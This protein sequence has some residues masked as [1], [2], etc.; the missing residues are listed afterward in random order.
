M[1]Q[2]KAVDP[3]EKFCQQSK[4]SIHFTNI[5]KYS[6]NLEFK[7]RPDYTYI[8]FLLKK[9]VLDID[10]VPMKMFDWQNSQ[11]HKSNNVPFDNTNFDELFK[12]Y[13]KLSETFGMQN[14]KENIANMQEKKLA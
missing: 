6:Y 8:K 11:G 4:N 7:E 13:T 14:Y 12:D 9:I 10:K 2:I 3:A 1:K 5:L